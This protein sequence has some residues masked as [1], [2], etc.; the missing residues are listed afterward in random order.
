VLLRL[1]TKKNEL[2]VV[3]G[4]SC[5]HAR[6]HARTDFTLLHKHTHTQNKSTR[7][8][9]SRLWTTATRETHVFLALKHTFW[10]PDHGK[11]PLYRNHR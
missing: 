2:M 9:Q 6:T 4:T 3:P 8:L 7:W 5:E 10:S 1:T 11:E